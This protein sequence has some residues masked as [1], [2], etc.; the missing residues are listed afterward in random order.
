MTQRWKRWISIGTLIAV[1]FTVSTA[2]A[3]ARRQN[4]RDRVNIAS[5]KGAD[6]IWFT[7]FTEV[8]KG[9]LPAGVTS[10]VSNGLVTTELTDI[11]DGAEKNC[12]KVVDTD[13]GGGYF[14]TNTG[15]SIP[16][17]SGI[18]G[19]QMR[20][21]YTAEGS[22][23]FN[24]IC[25]EMQNKGDSTVI[26][27]RVIVASANGTFQLQS[28]GTGSP[29]GS[30]Q[31]SSG[32]WYTLTYVMDYDKQRVDARL[33]NEA[34][35]VSSIVTDATFF[36]EQAVPSLNR[37]GFIT[38]QFGGT[39][40][41]DYMRVFKA[42]RLE[43]EEYTG[44][45]G[46]PA[47]KIKAPVSA[48]VAGRIN[49]HLNG[50]YKYTT[51]A[52]YEKDGHV[53]VSVKNLASFFGMRYSRLDS[54]DTISDET[55]TLTLRAGSTMQ[56]D[57]REISLSVPAELMEKQLFVPVDDICTAL[58]YGYEWKKDD[59]TVYITRNSEEGVK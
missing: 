29:L 11:G 45:R 36:A 22:S 47:E 57:G 50:R 51:A 52:P 5:H 25:I 38:N 20:F 35:G 15:F 18:V 27:S 17:Q 6:D 9:L 58:G 2:F 53:M 33:R 21:R 42:Q 28:N 44:V 37:I 39:W 54:G 13:H 31:V 26:G 59:N 23:K 40:H 7:D 46:V 10:I 55:H 19:L 4:P 16:E 48:P 12:L 3:A 41:I 43:E 49:L 56:A 8:K 34:K 24:S 1:C 30:E 14:S 32:D